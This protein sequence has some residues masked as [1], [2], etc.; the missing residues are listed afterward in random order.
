VGI[1]FADILV[2]HNL[3]FAQ[4]MKKPARAGFLQLVSGNLAV[5]RTSPADL[6]ALSAC[7]TGSLRVV[8]EVP[9]AYPAAFSSHSCLT[10]EFISTF[11]K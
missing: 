11:I 6:A 3:P 8:P 9:A 1:S 10:R 7:F 4:A 2:E 5:R